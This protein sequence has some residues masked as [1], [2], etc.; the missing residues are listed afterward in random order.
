MTDRLPIGE[1]VS[2][3]T[4]PFPSGGRLTGRFVTLEPV[5]AMA[6]GPA[7][8][9]ASHGDAQTEALWTYLFVGPFGSELAMVSWLA[10]CQESSDTLY[11]TVVDTPS[12]RPLGM[13]S[14][15]NVAPDMRRLEIGNIWY[16]PAAQ[17]TAANTEAAYLLLQEAFDLGYR[18]VEWK[19][20]ALNARSRE[21]ALRLGFQFEGVFRQHMVVKGRKRDTAWFAMTDGDWPRVRQNTEAWLAQ[22]AMA[23][24]R[25]SLT[26]MN[27]VR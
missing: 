10:T 24:P 16:G 14:Y 25:L 7:L 27:A 6:H 26:E 18:R 12:G 3:P 5:D 9:A 4:P 1:R 17:H 22:P 2:G 23:S 19:C 20:D 11:Y 13:T 21:A 15:L 8:Y